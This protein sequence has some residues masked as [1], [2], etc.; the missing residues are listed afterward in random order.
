MSLD[1][2]LVWVAIL[3]LAV[4]MYVLL[5]GFDLGIGI[6]FPLATPAERD[7]MMDTVTPFWDGNETWLVLGGAGLFAAF[8]KA[9]AAL[10]PALYI[11]ILT[12]LMALIVRGVAFEF[13]LNGRQRGKRFWT[14][15]FA[16]A[17][18]TATI[19][20]GLALGGFIRGVTL[21]NDQ[22]AGGH[23]DW[24]TP[25]SLLVA[26][27]LVAGYALLGATW[28]VWRTDDDLHARARRWAWTA[29][30]SVA[31]IL[32]IVSGATLLVH[33]EVAARW[34]YVDGSFDPARLL[35]LSPI[36]MLGALGLA[37]IALALRQRAHVWPFVGAALVFLSGYL[38]LAAGFFPYVVPYVM[39]F[40]RA[41]NPDNTL[42]LLLGGAAILLPTILGYTIWVYW[43]F[44]GKVDADGGTYH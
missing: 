15:A 14:A 42:A 30:A 33:P 27:G 2:P 11:P 12:M 26:A 32:A 25:Y 31:A 4:L 8:P 44:R 28:L 17:S 5:D 41:A 23:F 39:D 43:L 21:R 1:L 24:L 20:Q 7:Q 36:P 22:F 10:L 34:G 13:R 37:V 6:L 35:R 9:Y 16:A 3:A 19:A 18:M 40:R 29:A 38:G